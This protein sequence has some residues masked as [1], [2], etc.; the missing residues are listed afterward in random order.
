MTRA[1]AGEPSMRGSSTL[2]RCIFA[3]E[4]KYDV[5]LPSTVPHHDFVYNTRGGSCQQHCTQYYQYRLSALRVCR[6]CRCTHGVAERPGL[7]A[8][9]QCSVSARDLRPYQRKRLTEHLQ[10]KVDRHK[11][12]VANNITAST[13][14]GV[15]QTVG[16]SRYCIVTLIDFTN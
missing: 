1:G 13:N 12:N 3:H 6:V 16:K 2:S 7:P 11:V 8:S 14:S 9:T 5:L 15:V 4:F 10:H